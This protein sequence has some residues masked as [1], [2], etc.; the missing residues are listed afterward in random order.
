MG[1]LDPAVGVGRAVVVEPSP[2]QTRR[3][4]EA[5]ERR[6]DVARKVV[7]RLTR[8]EVRVAVIELEGRPAIADMSERLYELWSRDYPIVGIYSQGA[9]PVDIAQDLEAA[10]L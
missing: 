6:L 2:A 7:A 3:A 9:R 8:P 5:A 10:G 4:Q 1:A